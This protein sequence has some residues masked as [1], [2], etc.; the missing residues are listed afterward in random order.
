MLEN[1]RDYIFEYWTWIHLFQNLIWIWWLPPLPSDQLLSSQAL[2]LRIFAPL[3]FLACKTTT[4]LFLECKSFTL[5]TDIVVFFCIKILHFQVR[6]CVYLQYETTKGLPFEKACA[7][8]KFETMCSFATMP[9]RI[10][11]VTMLS[12]RNTEYTQYSGV[13]N[14]AIVAFSP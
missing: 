2:M 12:Y 8:Y 4:C 11:N 7:F 1:V 10:V 9:V 14:I 3:C 6:A 5:I 13:W